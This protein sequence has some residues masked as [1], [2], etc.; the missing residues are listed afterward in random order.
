MK[1]E[2]TGRSFRRFFDAAVD[3]MLLADEDGRI[4]LAN[5]AAEGLFGYTGAELCG[6]VVEDLIPLPLRPRHR[7]KRTEYAAHP[8]RR[9]RG[10]NLDIRGLRK[11]GGEFPA[12]VSLSPLE[13]GLV[14]ATVHDIS[15]RRRVER[16]LREQ[17]TEMEQLLK[18]RVA[19][20]TAVAIAHEM[21]QPLNAI[22]SHNETALRLLRAGNPRPERLVHALEHSA[23]QVQRAGRAMRHLVEFLHKGETV[24]EALDLNPVVRGALAIAAADGHDGLRTVIDLAPGLSPVQANRVQVEMVL[25]NLLRNGVE[26]MRAMGLRAGSIVVTVRTAADRNMAQVTVCDSGPGL[27]AAALERLFKPFYT[28]KPTGIGMGL[29]VS[30]ALIE[31]HGGRLWLET[32]AGP[33]ASFHFTLPFAR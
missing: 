18:L 10:G 8:R 15:E 17:R 33:G 2:L 28:T 31:A 22:A 3:P 24:T 32:D 20:Q 13:G 16:E 6:L 23:Q 9:M 7:H 27:D 5:S 12:E 21:N 14:L 25:V 29:A 26:A 19:S 11:N 1:D 4:V 30:R